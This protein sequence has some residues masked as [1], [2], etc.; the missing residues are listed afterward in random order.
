MSALLDT[1]NLDTM[2]DLLGEDFR[3]IVR[4]YPAQ[5]DSELRSMEQARPQQDW[6]LL[7][8][9]AHMLQGSSGN[10]GA[11]ALAGQA[12]LLEC[13]AQHAD[14]QAADA[15]LA[16]LAPLVAQTRSALLE[17]GYV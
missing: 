9:L 15:A 12:A 11:A 5:L 14:A 16:A 2:L 10:V 13:A 3:A 4:Q 6:A 8:R 17:A 7:R 1:A